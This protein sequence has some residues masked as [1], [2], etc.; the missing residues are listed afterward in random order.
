MYHKPRMCRTCLQMS[1]GDFKFVS[2]DSVD[3]LWE[4]NLPNLKE[5]LMYLV[6]EMVIIRFIN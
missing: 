1:R 6:P 2:L 4:S 3:P 5:Q